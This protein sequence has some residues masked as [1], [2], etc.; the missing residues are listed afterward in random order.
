[1]N[2]TPFSIEKR[3]T[4]TDLSNFIPSSHSQPVKLLG[5]IIDG[6]LSDRKSISELEKKLLSGFKTI[7]RFL[8]KGAQKLWILEHI[9]V[10]RIQWPLMIYKISISAA[11]N[12]ER[13]Y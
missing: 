8:F 11:S 13:K 10:P 9:L 2:L 12:L 7:D 6:S 4:P 3:S 5:C 1:M